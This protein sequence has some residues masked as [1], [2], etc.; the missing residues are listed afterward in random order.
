MTVEHNKKEIA[1][2]IDQVSDYISN[3]KAFTNYIKGLLDK[4]QFKLTTSNVFLDKKGALI[5]FEIQYK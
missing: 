4:T 5:V 3:K 1:I 2:R